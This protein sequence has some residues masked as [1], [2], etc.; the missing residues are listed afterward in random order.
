VEA[1]LL[2]GGPAA[3]A[4]LEEPLRLGD[5]T[6]RVDSARVLDAA[7]NRARE[8]LRVVEDYCRFVLGD[9][10]L[11]RE[12][13]E[14]RHGL[15]GGV[16]GL[17]AGPLLLEGREALRGGGVSI[18]T[19]DEGRRAGL[20]DVARANLKRLEEALRSL[21][22]FAKVHRPRLG[23]ELEGMRYRAYTV[24]RALLLGSVAR[25]RLRDAHLYVL[26]GGASCAA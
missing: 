9:A 20:L 18:S 6:E 7:G 23:Q 4:A 22:E 21:E 26:L 3:R 14:L 24:E 16:R 11:S 5:V 25:Q 2:R 1:A 8:A 10:L 19:E 15:A 13:K 12:L 17:A